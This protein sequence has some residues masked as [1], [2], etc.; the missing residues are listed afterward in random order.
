MI[1]L[2]RVILPVDDVASAAE[3]YSTLLAMPGMRISPGRHYFDCGGVI[4]ALYSPKA[5]GDTAEPRPNFEH[6]SF[7]VDDLDAVH[8]RARQLG[9]LSIETG[10]GRLPMGEIAV[11]PWGER[12][13]YM[14]DRFGNPL[15]LVDARTVFTG[16]P[17]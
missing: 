17:A 13:F 16:P 4:L 9:G 2:Y 1:Q 5:D 11:R 7:A 15:C 14:R 8:A 6:V 3:F 12:S 10:D